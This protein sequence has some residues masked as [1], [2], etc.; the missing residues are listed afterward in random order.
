M[1]AW[2]KSLKQPCNE[3]GKQFDNKIV[4]EHVDSR[5][6]AAIIDYCYTGHIEVTMKNVDKIVGA[7]LH[8]EIE[9]VIRK[10]ERW[11]LDAVTFENCVRAYEVAEKYSFAELRQ[12]TMDMMIEHFDRIPIGDLQK[13]DG[14]VLREL[15]SCNNPLRSETILFEIVFKRMEKDVVDQPYVAPHFLKIIELHQFS[16]EVSPIMELLFCQPR[17]SMI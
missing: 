8:M 13:L 16:G 12:K 5:S 7:A 1:A 10:C 3:Q 15:F 9:T 17:R 6:L 4:V 2:C 14:K 11:W